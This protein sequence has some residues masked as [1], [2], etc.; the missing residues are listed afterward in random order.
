MAGTA[1]STAGSKHVRDEDGNDDI[2]EVAHASGRLVRPPQPLPQRSLHVGAAAAAPS[3][4]AASSSVRFLYRHALESIFAFASL[5]DLVILFQVCRDW[6]SA[7]ISMPCRHFRVKFPVF[8]APLPLPCLDASYSTAVNA[9]HISSIRAA[10]HCA[11]VKVKNLRHLRGFRELRHFSLSLKKPFGELPRRQN[12]WEL[13]VGLRSLEIHLD[14][15]WQGDSFHARTHLTTLL[16]AIARLEHLETLTIL[17]PGGQHFMS[18]DVFT[19]VMLPLTQM[20]SLTELAVHFEEIPKH[21]HSRLLRSFQNLRRLNT[22]WRVSLN[23]LLAAPHSLHQLQEF[24]YSGR[25]SVGD[26]DLGIIA[27]LPNLHTLLLS[28]VCAVHIDVVRSLAF[29]SH[30]SLSFDA[31]IEVDTARVMSALATCT[32]LISLALRRPSLTVDPWLFSS[33]QLGECLQHMPLLQELRLFSCRGI[34]SLSFLKAGTTTLADTL[35]TLYLG[36]CNMPL[37]EMAVTHE[38]KVLQTL[39]IS[40]H[41]FIE[42]MEED[43]KMAYHPPSLLIPTLKS[44]H[45][46]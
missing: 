24:R 11:P 1:A 43:A 28:E 35:T 3:A 41:T 36:D 2:A 8:L 17:L 25:N 13:P 39:H 26:P 34:D 16:L 40:Y 33:V 30:L 6:Q 46:A 23:D 20:A 32:N 45:Y 22:Y 12:A 31:W 7:V 9:R 5:P 37:V 29:L 15:D 44:F 27:T 10:T 42:H 38:L 14:E 21:L 18:N 4:A 19:Q